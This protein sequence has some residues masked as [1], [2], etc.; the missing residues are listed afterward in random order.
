MKDHLNIAVDLTPMLP[1]GENGGVKFAILE[2]LRGLKRFFG[3]RFTFLLV[4][5]DDSHHEVTSLLGAGDTAVCVLRRRRVGLGTALQA[6]ESATL[7]RLTVQKLFREHQIDLFYCPFGLLSFPSPRIPTVAMVVDLLHRDFPLSISAQTRE[8]RELQFRKLASYVDFYQVISDFTAQRLQTIYQV[9]SHQ[10]FKT[11]LPIQH[12]LRIEKNEHPRKSFFFYPANFWIHKNH[13]VLLMAY[14]IYLANMGDRK[15][16]DLILTGYLDER[17]RFLQR[18]ADDLEISSRVEFLGHVPETE[19]G[20]LYS[21]SSC[22]V[23]PSLH[24][25]FGIPIIEAMSFGTPIVCGR[26][27]SIP[28][29]AGEAALYTD[30]RNPLELASALQRI[31]EDENLRDTL[32]ARGKRQLGKFDFFMEVKRLADAFAAAAEKR[33]RPKKSRWEALWT[34]LYF[35]GIYYGRAIARKA[36]EGAVSLPLHLERM[37]QLR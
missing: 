22:L 4:T 35:G 28:E 26:E 6:L 19:L 23:F 27:A 12:R 34:N 20:Q 2:F 31:T 8:W 3:E 9:P 18:L 32:V 25:G 30:T 21:N 16:W 11:S 17:A 37:Q 13:E 5:A 7:S 24:E 14:Q 10:I 33:S 36:L 29:V 15:A 1:G